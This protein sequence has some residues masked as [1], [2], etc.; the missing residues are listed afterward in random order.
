MGVITY[1]LLCG[2]TP[3]DRDSQEQEMQAICPDWVR[4]H[5]S[6]ASV[7]KNDFYLAME[8]C[9]MESSK[10][11][12]GQWLDRVEAMSDEELGQE[13]LDKAYISLYDSLMN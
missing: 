6:G 1:F 5:A 12:I 10:R 2:Y 9:D 8:R 7:L 13:A 11:R 3:F 4:V